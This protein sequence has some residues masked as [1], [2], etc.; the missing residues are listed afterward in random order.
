MPLRAPGDQTRDD[1]PLDDEVRYVLHDEPVFDRARFA[2]IGIA[3]D[4]FGA[5]HCIANDLPF[6]AGRKSG[7]AQTAKAAGFEG[8]DGP[9]KISAFE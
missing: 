2:L 7:P 8:G 1:H 6:C 3:N 4:I 5:S 9:E